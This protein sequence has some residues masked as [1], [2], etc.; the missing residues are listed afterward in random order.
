L[1]LS[2]C[3][4]VVEDDE[5]VARSLVALLQL[6]GYRASRYESAELFLAELEA[7]PP[8]CL[9]IDHALP[10]ATGLDAVRTLRERGIAWPAIL[11]SGH[12]T[13]DLEADAKRIGVRGVLAKPF[14]YEHLAAELEGAARFVPNPPARRF[15]RT[16][17]LVADKG[18]RLLP[19]A[20]R[21]RGPGRGSSLGAAE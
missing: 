14:H 15:R 4:Y 11:M 3:V 17:N 19:A 7:L 16:R 6:C 10:G 13:A 12:E 5:S 21:P 18:W 20:I 9:L 8:G 2:C 1:A